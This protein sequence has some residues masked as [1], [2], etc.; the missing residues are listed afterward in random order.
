MKTIK[1]SIEIAEKVGIK[2][3]RKMSYGQSLYENLEDYKDYI[4]LITRN[5]RGDELS[6]YFYEFSE[7]A[8]NWLLSTGVSFQL[9][10]YKRTWNN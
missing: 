5:G 6:E 7:T 8:F 9:N 4:I 10:E 3:E 2:Y 1:F